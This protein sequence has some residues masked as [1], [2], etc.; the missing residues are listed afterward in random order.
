[1]VGV[2]EFEEDGSVSNLT[3]QP[4]QLPNANNDV[5]FILGLIYPSCDQGPIYPLYWGLVENDTLY[6]PV[7]S[8]C[9][10]AQLYA[11]GV[12]ALDATGSGTCSSSSFTESM[13]VS[14]FSGGYG[15]E[16]YFSALGAAGWDGKFELKKDTTITD[17]DAVGRK[18]DSTNKEFDLLVTLPS[19]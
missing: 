17:I 9:V 5:T 14:S 6:F 12:V 16:V 8:F 2:F 13:I 19:D 10:R 4:R 18:L 15:N 7:L 11:G 3:P 1:M